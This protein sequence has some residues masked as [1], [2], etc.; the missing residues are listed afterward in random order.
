[1]VYRDTAGRCDCA[2]RNALVHRLEQIETPAMHVLR[3]FAQ[4]AVLESCARDHNSTFRFDFLERHIT[5]FTCAAVHHH[6]GVSGR[7]DR[8]CITS[9]VG[10]QLAFGLRLMVVGI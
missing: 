2:R 1:M 10:E 3:A 7:Y 9:C 5:F 6:D 8:S 4:G